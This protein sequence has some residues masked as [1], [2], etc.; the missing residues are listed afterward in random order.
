MICFRG[1]A[2]RVQLLDLRRQ[3]IRNHGA[4]G[5]FRRLRSACGLWIVPY[6]LDPLHESGACRQRWQL[7]LRILPAQGKQHVQLMR[8]ERSAVFSEMLL[9]L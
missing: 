3:D 7:N 4:F 8:D 1:P 5:L 2:V 9:L 6:L